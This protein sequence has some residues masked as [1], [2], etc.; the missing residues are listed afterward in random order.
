VNRVD[1][2]FALRVPVDAVAEFR[3]LT[4]T[5]PPEYGGTSG[6]TT[7][8][9]TR[10]GGNEFHGVLYEFLRN[11]KLDARNFFSAEVEP[12][13]QNQFGAT[14][15]GPI[16]RDRLFFYGYYEGFRNRQGITRAAVVPT[17]GQRQGD[18]SNLIDPQTGQPRMLINYLTG[19]PV[20]NNQIPADRIHPI[21]LNVQEYYPLGNLGPSLFS[22]TE[23]GT[24]DYDQGGVR[25]DWML[26]GR[27]PF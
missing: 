26:G 4:H 17:P 19:Q 3:I 1:G 22:S 14:L 24:N 13:K 10:S 12:L 18:F 6:S 23:V 20:P 11:D 21:S 8:V 27:D 5:A 25:V 9:V 16:Q 2:G 7:S 15:G